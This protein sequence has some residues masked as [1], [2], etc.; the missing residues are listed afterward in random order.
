MV[1]FPKQIWI[2]KRQRFHYLHEWS[3]IERQN[4]GWEE[5]GKTV[6]QR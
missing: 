1:C 2:L 6:V 5:T 3:E 4:A